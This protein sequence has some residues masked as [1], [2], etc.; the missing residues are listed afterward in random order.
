MSERPAR[1]PPWRVGLVLALF[2]AVCAGAVSLTWELTRERIEDNRA[3]L[4]QQRFLPLLDGITWATRS[5][6][7][8]PTTCP[9]ASRP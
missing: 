4:R 3:A 9:G 7:S 5:G 6:S 1:L 2:A 8:R